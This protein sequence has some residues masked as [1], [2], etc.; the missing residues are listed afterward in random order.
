V[1]TYIDPV[2][3]QTTDYGVILYSNTTTAREY[4]THLG[5]EYGPYVGYFPNGSTKYI[6]YTNGN[7]LSAPAPGNATAANEIYLK[8][9]LSYGDLFSTPGIYLP[10]P[11]P[12]NLLLPWGEWLKK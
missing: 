6:D 1:A 11:V 10:D 7:V 5:V 2:I 4:F 12:A 3:N 9:M 8:Q